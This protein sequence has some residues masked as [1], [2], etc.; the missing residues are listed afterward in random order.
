[1]GADV[2][3]FNPRDPAVLRFSGAAVDR[4][5]DFTCSRCG[6][7]QKAWGDPP[8]DGLC[9]GCL[10]DVGAERAAEQERQRQ[11]NREAAI[12][13]RIARWPETL[14]ELGVPAEYRRVPLKLSM[15][16]SCRAW[17]GKPW[18]ITILGLTGRG[19]SWLATRV[20]GELAC[21]YGDGLWIDVSMAVERIHADIRAGRS[22]MMDEL[23]S[24]PVL[25]FDDLLAERSDLP[26]VRDKIGFV[27][28]T[29]YNDQLATLI[30]AN[31]I[32]SNP[33]SATCGQPSLVGIDQ[34][35]P[36]GRITSRLSAGHVVRM[37]GVDRRTER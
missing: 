14:A 13:E 2:N 28:R 30:T 34:I 27:L 29:R 15:P 11:V 32:D 22:R 19:K 21:Q 20:W 3:R 37:T 6:D 4:W 5:V 10:V 36:D 9:D 31:A 1:M 17:R 24:T 12:A 33:E 16:T 18:S 8:P 26:F 7:P 23:I 35:D 25:L